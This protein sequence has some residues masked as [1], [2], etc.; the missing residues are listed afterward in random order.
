MTDTLK[1]INNASESQT[2][3]S[4]IENL[5]PQLWPSLQT[6]LDEI[7]DIAETEKHMRPQSEIMEDLVSQVRG[8]NG[9]MRDFD[10]E[11]MERGLRF[12]R[13]RFRKIHPAMLDDLMMMSNEA[14]RGGD[15][16][17]LMLAGMVRDT[18]PWMSEVLVEGHRELKSASPKQAKKIAH[19]LR[20]ALKFMTRSPFAEMMMMDK[21]KGTT[22]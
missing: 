4:T 22:I 17:L 14:P 8:L 10:P 2:K 18:M 13:S 7:P 21:S 19:D 9:R 16:G 1:A 20:Q 12:G 6:K 11:M 3:E 5:V 15:Y